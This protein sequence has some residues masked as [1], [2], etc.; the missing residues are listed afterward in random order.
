MGEDNTYNIRQNIMRAD[1]TLSIQLPNF[2]FS[3]LRTKI[4]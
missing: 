1:V 2:R 4:L 3:S